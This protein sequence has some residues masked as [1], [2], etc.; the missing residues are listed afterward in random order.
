[1]RRHWSFETPKRAAEPA[2][3]NS[4]WPAHALDRFV[5]A[6]LE[7][8]GLRPSPPADAR[9]LVRRLYLDLTG[10]PPTPEET[11]AFVADRSPDAFAK[12][13]ERLLA[14]LAY[15]ERWGR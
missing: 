1:M 13:V 3:G 11:A 10:L 7:Q 4:D 12:L 5:L 2:V 9:T 14:S 8:E 15:G 6:R